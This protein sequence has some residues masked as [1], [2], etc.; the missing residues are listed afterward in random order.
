MIGD[1][2]ALSQ[3]PELVNLF[4]LGDRIVCHPNLAVKFPT[5]AKKEHAKLLLPTTRG[6]LYIN[7]MIVEMPD[8][9]GLSNWALRDVVV[10]NTL[11]FGEGWVFTQ[12]PHT[13][14]DTASGILSNMYKRKMKGTRNQVIIVPEKGEPIQGYYIVKKQVT[15]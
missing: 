11:D 3:R 9:R 2:S 13:D 5:I 8:L 10:F 6:L 1:L 14:T 15:V 12:G 7:V 4:E